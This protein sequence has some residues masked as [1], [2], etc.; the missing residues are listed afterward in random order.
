MARF[1]SYQNSGS[2][3]TVKISESHQRKN[4]FSGVFSLS[5]KDASALLCVAMSSAS[6]RCLSISDLSSTLSLEAAFSINKCSFLA[7]CL[8]FFSSDSGV[9]NCSRIMK[10]VISYS[11]L[12]FIITHLI[13][14]S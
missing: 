1:I 13:Y 6:R 5:Y 11:T 9:R 4:P 3:P 2:P 7:S 12:T 8:M 14:L 10:L